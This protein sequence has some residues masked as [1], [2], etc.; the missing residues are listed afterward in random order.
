VLQKKKK[1][2]KKKGRKKIKERGQMSHYEK[3][4]KEQ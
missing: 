1:K 4:L 2:K 3:F